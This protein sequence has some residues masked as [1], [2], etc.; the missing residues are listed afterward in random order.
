MT[1]VLGIDAAWTAH[2]PS[3]VALVR[4]NPDQRWECVAL[5]PSYDAFVEIAGGNT[6]R[7]DERPKGGN[8]E[9]ERLLRA[10]EQRLGGERVTVVSVDMPI[11]RAP[12]T[13]RREADKAISRAFG[14]N[15]CGTHTP[16]AT[17]PGAISA[18]LRES[19]ASL[20]YTLA[21]SEPDTC[22]VIEVYP[23]PAL[24]RLL[25]RT[26]RVPYKV[27]RTLR[28]WPRLSISKP[29]QSANHRI[30]FDIRRT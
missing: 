21:V 24:L 1:S 23:H 27:D 18:Q 14:R 19:L 5:A 12:I 3:G 30:Q 7:W 10:A 26:Y 15:G 25:Q 9:P 28:Y 6:V 11:S 2:N 4:T 8:P 20:G 13:R 22:T 16:N 17:R 29:S